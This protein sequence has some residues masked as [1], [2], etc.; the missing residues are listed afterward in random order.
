MN[1]Q[2][3]LRL[4]PWLVRATIPPGLA[5][6]YI[7]HRAG[8]PIYVGRSD[9]DLQRRL[10]QHCGTRRGDYFSYDTHYSATAAFEVE[11]SLYHSFRDSITNILHPDAPNFSNARCPFCVSQLEQVLASRINARSDYSPQSK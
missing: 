8:G 10:I 11:C 5:G 3:L 2:R 1:G 6:T 7:L 9:T 4:Q